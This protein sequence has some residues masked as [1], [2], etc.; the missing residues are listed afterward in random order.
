MRTLSTTVRALTA[1][2]TDKTKRTNPT[3]TLPLL[4]YLCLLSTYSEVAN[5]HICESLISQTFKSCKGLSSLTITNQLHPLY[6]FIANALTTSNT[7]SYFKLLRCRTSLSR[8]SLIPSLARHL[9][10]PKHE[11]H[12]LSSTFS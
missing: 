1:C 5:S 7:R 3:K 6:P 8:S 11:I 12:L 9:I 10:I 4:K 2:K